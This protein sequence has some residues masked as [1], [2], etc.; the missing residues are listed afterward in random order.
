MP[1]SS[2]TLSVE[3]PTMGMNSGDG[4]T[5]NQSEM[6]ERKTHDPHSHNLPKAV[7]PTAS[8]K[9]LITW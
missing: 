1:N 9:H 4:D 3:T 5:G 8:H 2:I 7:T 6:P